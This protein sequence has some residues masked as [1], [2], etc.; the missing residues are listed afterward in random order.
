M[1]ETN[2]LITQLFTIRNRYGKQAASEK[3][4]LL[5]NI[6]IKTVKNKTAVASLYTALLFLI[7][8]PDNKMIYGS[9]NKLLQELEA[10]L[11]ANEKLTYSLYNSGITRTKLSAAFSFEMVKWLRETRPTEI[12]FNSFEATDAQIQSILSV[13]MTKTESEILQDANAAWKGWLKHIK[14]PGQDLLDQFIVI[15]GSSDTRPEV[16]DELWNAIG[17]N[18]EISF[19]S[20]CCL[21]ASLVKVY[22]NR[23]LIRKQIKQHAIQKL[24]PVKLSQ[25]EAEQIIDCSRMILLRKLREL[26]PISFSAAKNVSYYHLERGISIALMGMVP[27]RRHPIDSYMGYL[28]FKNG[29]PVAYAGSWILFDSARIGLNVFSDYRGGEAKYIFEQVLQ[30]HAKVYHLKRFTVDPYQLGKENSDGINSGAFW[31]YYHAGFRPLEKLQQELAEAEEIKIR[32]GKT[33]RSPALVLKTLANSR[34]ELVLQKNAVRFDATD[35]SL[36]YAAILAKKYKGDR[37]PEKDA[38]KKLAGILKIK[39]PHDENIKF[40]LK[41]WSVLLLSNEKELKNN[42]GLKRS[43]KELVILK[44]AGSE[45]AYITALQ[46]T[47]DLRKFITL[48]LKEMLIKLP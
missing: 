19:T 10:H 42:S 16:K 30:L 28:V 3:L 43:L 44:A 21:P 13:V 48:L 18:V 22:Y 5:N 33:Y 39:N 20:H 32:S 27:G 6:K 36:L 29:L 23:S 41:N 7:A 11:H 4:Q 46:K 12:S 25:H 14:E 9:A 26:D 1:R 38:V 47:A 37:R 31:I 34:L 15:F 17:I 2:A 35:L 8:Y 45:E 40:V 24:T